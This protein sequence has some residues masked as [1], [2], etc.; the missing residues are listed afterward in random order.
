MM[1][2]MSTTMLQTP[3]VLGFAAACLAMLMVALRASGRA[4]RQ[5]SVTCAL[6]VGLIALGGALAALLQ[7][8]LDVGAT[9]EFVAATI[10]LTW[11]GWFG[12]H[13]AR[14]PRTSRPAPATA[15]LGGGYREICQQTIAAAADHACGR[16][17]AG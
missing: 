17:A 7:A 9:L 14:N 13:V 16:Q 1:G 12:L 8:G 4:P 15:R 10:A 3:F 5:L 6:A 11:C 2:E